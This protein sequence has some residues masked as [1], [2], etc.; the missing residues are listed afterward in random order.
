[1]YLDIK[2]IHNTYYIYFQF[3]TIIYK[4]YNNVFMPIDYRCVV[5]VILKKKHD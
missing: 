2:N 4:V 1:M 5:V 3:Y